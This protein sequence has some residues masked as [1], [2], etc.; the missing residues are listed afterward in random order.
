[1]V[2]VANLGIKDGLKMRVA[3]T[4]VRLLELSNGLTLEAAESLTQELR[5]ALDGVTGVIQP[6][7]FVSI[8]IARLDNSVTP[9]MVV[10]A[11]AKTRRC[12]VGFVKAGEV[13]VGPEDLGI[14]VARCPMAAAKA[15]ADGG[16]ILISWS[17]NPVVCPLTL[18]DPIGRRFQTS[19]MG[20]ICHQ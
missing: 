2:N 19:E 3:A 20:R 4:G 10:A 11:V 7:K 18:L 1:M 5:T 15:L 17:V 13:S 9:K 8:R 6:T 12:D 14:V 16:S